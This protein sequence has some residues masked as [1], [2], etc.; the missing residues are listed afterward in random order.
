MA[1]QLLL[2]KLHFGILISSLIAVESSAGQCDSGIPT[3]LK[4]KVNLVSQTV[5]S[6]SFI[7]FLWQIYKVAVIVSL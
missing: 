5:F 1:K 2:S 6:L 7:V 4:Q 3:S